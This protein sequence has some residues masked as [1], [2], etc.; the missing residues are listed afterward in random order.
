M[1]HEL[2]SFLVWLVPMG[3][4]S[5]SVRVLCAVG[6]SHQSL[7]VVLPLDLGSLLKQELNCILLNTHREFCTV[8]WVSYSV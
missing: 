3:T 5:D 7:Q 4:F 1:S 2:R 6:C 8:L